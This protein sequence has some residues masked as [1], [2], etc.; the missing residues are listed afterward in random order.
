M[1]VHLSVG[2]LAGGIQSCQRWSRC[3]S[4]SSHQSSP[5]LLPTSSTCALETT[6]SNLRY[7][8]SPQLT[9][10]VAN[11]HSKTLTLHHSV[12]VGDFQEK[13]GLIKTHTTKCVPTI[14]FWDAD[15]N[16]NW[17]I[18]K[19]L[20]IFCRMFHQTL[21]LAAVFRG[22]FEVGFCQFL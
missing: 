2:S 7:W 12:S 16:A 1:C 20:K 9:H 3:C 6:R 11:V 21:F 10:P 15:R 17:C 8:S 4:T 18:L 5:T 14:P 19:I 22:V 13:L